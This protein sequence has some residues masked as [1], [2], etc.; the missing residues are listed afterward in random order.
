MK[1]DGDYVERDEVIAE[2][3]SEKATFELNAEQAGVLKRIG[4]E[5]DTLNI[6]DPVAQIDEAAAKPVGNGQQATGNTQAANPQIHP[7][8]L[9]RRRA[10]NRKPTSR[11][12]PW[13]PPSLPIKKLTRRTYSHRAPTEKF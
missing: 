9:L 2:L 7:P 3:E 13:P 8:E 12:L 5:G 11:L 1:K 10:T 6:G 4:A